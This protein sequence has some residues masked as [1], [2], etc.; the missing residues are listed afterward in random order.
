[1]CIIVYKP[2][3]QNLPSKEILHNCFERNGDGIGYTF[4]LNNKVV[5][6]KGYFDFNKFYEDVTN[7]F[8]RF[9]LFDKNMIL[10]FRISTSVAINEYKTHPFVLT[11]QKEHIEHKNVFCG[12]SV[13]HN[14][15]LYDYEKKNGYTDTQNFILDFLSP[16]LR[17]FNYDFS[18][19]LL[20]HIIKTELRTSKICVLSYNDDVLKVGDFIKDNG[21]Y[22]SNTSYKKWEYKP[23]NKTCQKSLFNYNYNTGLSWWD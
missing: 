4:T 9:K 8:K 20:Q 13:V 1:M 15:V 6:K 3:K 14:G 2:K 18:D 11:S 22:Y 12:Y 16:L 10:H 19:T 5:I 21:I 17:R 7:D 23:I